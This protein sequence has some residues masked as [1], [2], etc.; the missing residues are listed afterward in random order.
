MLGEAGGP[1][2]P[3]KI[4]ALYELSISVSP[5][6]HAA[7]HAADHARE[8]HKRHR[9]E[10]IR[11]NDLTCF[12]VHQKSHSC[13]HVQQLQPRIVLVSTGMLFGSEVIM[14]V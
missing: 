11:G 2:N 5:L 1:E 10:A 6:L 14:N 7:E 9:V 12:P 13:T 8:V 3:W 4:C